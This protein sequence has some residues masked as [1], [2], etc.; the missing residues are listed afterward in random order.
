MIS[1]LISHNKHIPRFSIGY[2]HKRLTKNKIFHFKKE[3]PRQLEQILVKWKQLAYTLETSRPTLDDSSV[4][5]C[6]TKCYWL[7][8]KFRVVLMTHL[9]MVTYQS[10]A[11][12]VFSIKVCTKDPYL[13]TAMPPG[14]FNVN[15]LFIYNPYGRP[16]SLISHQHQPGVSISFERWGGWGSQSG[17]APTIEALSVG[18]LGL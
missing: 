15:C 9:L 1:L 17:K 5:I 4:Y 12:G 11:T 18:A 16:L 13:A 8:K 6:F 14:S 2:A 7:T 10:Q 3:F